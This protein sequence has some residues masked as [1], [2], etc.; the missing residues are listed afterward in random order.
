VNPYPLHVAV[1]A[2]V[3]AIVAVPIAASGDDKARWRGLQPGKLVGHE[4]RVPVR[5]V[6]IGFE[7][8][9]V[10]DAALLAQLPSTSKPVVR[11][12][13]LYGLEGRTLGL[14]YKFAYEVVRKDEAFADKFFHYLKRLGTAGPLTPYQASYN[15]QL[16]NLVDITTPVLYIN[17]PSVEQWLKVHDNPGQ[18][19]H[20]VYFINWW[21]RSDFR[22]HVYTKLDESDPDTGVNFGE[23]A[24]NKMGSWGGTT[25]RHWFYDFSA[26]PT[27]RMENYVV[28]VTDVTG[29]GREDYR[30]PVIWEYDTAG[31]RLP[32]LLSV[33]IGL[34]TRF[35]AINLIFTPSPHY[36]PLVTAPGPSGSKVVH[37]SM[38][39]DDPEPANK[40]LNFVGPALVGAG[41]HGLQPYYKWTVGLQDFDPIDDG[42]KRSLDIYLRRSNEPDCWTSFGTRTAQLFCYFDQNLA[43]YVP[44]YGP[45]DYVA[46]V[47]AFNLGSGFGR[48]FAD[49][50]WV[51]GTQTF[52][53]VLGSV[54]HRQ[55]L[56]NGYTSETIHEMGHHFGLSHPFDGYDSEFDL[57]YDSFGPDFYFAWVGN[58]SHTVM[59]TPLSNSFGQ[60]NRDNMYRWETIGYLNWANVVAGA[61][62]ESP[63]AWKLEK[64]LKRA[65]QRAEQ[66][67]KGFR[68][69]DYLK[70]VRDARHAYITLV[71]AA[72]SI[73][74]T[75]AR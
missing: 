3:I 22:F 25:S 61:I 11:V 2:V 27:F 33:D 37:I 56:G 53:F 20:T 1:L 70:A 23:A 60:H 39:E 68:H 62:L 58:E 7:E 75:P 45:D 29:D 55:Q 30:M 18:S 48:S 5:I 15:D 38:F 49:D 59:G 73:G 40:G 69:W 17:A 4:H 43:A 71:E 28:D 44:P 24:E 57:E 67:L 41:L 12:P 21:N 6:L 52:T 46:E 66:A 16:K 74:V 31:Y 32:H 50:N 13:R 72:K 47:F 65:D 51:D 36:D 64:Q 14:T 35:V 8:G 34:L 10:D 63:D 42:S 9:Q 19:G 26:G 54:R